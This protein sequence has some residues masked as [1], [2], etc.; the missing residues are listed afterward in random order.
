MESSV[1][2]APLAELPR[3]AANFVVHFRDAIPSSRHE[4]SKDDLPSWTDC[5]AKLGPPP[6][7][8]GLDTRSSPPELK[9]KPLVPL[10]GDI[11][12]TVQ[13]PYLAMMIANTYAALGDKSAGLK[14]LNS[15]IEYYEKKFQSKRMPWQW[16]YDR[17]VLEYGIVQEADEPVPTTTPELKYLE[18]MQALFTTDWPVD[19]DNDGHKCDDAAARDL[20][21]IRLA[22]LIA[23]DS[24]AF[25]AGLQSR[26]DFL[27][28]NVLQRLLYALVQTLPNLDHDYLAPEH[29]HWARQ[30]ISSAERCLPGEAEKTR[31]WR[32]AL[33]LLSAGVVLARW[34]E[35]GPRSGLLYPSNVPDMQKDAVKTLL[36]ALPSIR[37]RE[38]ADERLSDGLRIDP[39][40]W[41]AYRRIA[42]RTLL[43]LQAKL[44]K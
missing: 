18:K 17:A 33:S 43:D 16:L 37:E 32:R 19:V 26:L 27:Y 25:E 2:F 44:T 30:L 15:W 14:V 8:P 10:W 12:V 41:E 11:G 39:S 29:E 42:E 31:E 24:K 38:T 36:A 13:P 22:K 3:Q 35:D 5:T 28:E 4:V 9:L 7:Y 23:G 21:A 6:W 34:A 40:Q 20:E 1:W